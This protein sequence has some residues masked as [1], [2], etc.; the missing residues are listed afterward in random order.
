MMQKN[1]VGK[2]GEQGLPPPVEYSHL[3]CITSLVKLKWLS[4]PTKEEENSGHSRAILSYHI[5]YNIMSESMSM[6]QRE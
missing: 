6:I 2:E 4:Q 3:C 5:L 1:E